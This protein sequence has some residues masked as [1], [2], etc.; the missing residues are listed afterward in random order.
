MPDELAS[1]NWNGH[2]NELMDIRVFTRCP[3]VRLYLN[4][5]LLEEKS[6]TNDQKTGI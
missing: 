2:E 6:I 5:G 4:N 3:I 1:W